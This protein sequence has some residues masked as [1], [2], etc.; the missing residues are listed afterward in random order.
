VQRTRPSGP[1]AGSG[2]PSGYGIKP[3]LSLFCG[4]DCAQKPLGIGCAGVRKSSL[5]VRPSTSHR[6]TFTRTRSVKSPTRRT[7]IHAEIRMTDMPSLLRSPQQPQGICACTVTSKAVVGSSAIRQTMGGRQSSG[8]R[9]HPLPHCPD[10]LVRIRVHARF[11]SVCD[12][13]QQIDGPFWASRRK[14]PDG[15]AGFPRSGH[16]RPTRISA[17]ASDPED[18]AMSRHAVRHLLSGSQ[19]NLVASKTDR[20][21][22]CGCCASWCSPRIE[23][24]V[25]DFPEPLSS[26]RSRCSLG[27]Q[28]TEADIC[29][30]RGSSHLRPKHH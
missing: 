6:H 25:T 20:P 22:G 26:P 8:W 13:I 9:H 4:R 21:W 7:Q 10:K 3:P 28:H 19:A 2:I 23:R 14:A 18:I 5:R 29:R 16:P 17:N 15:C 1:V 12:Q 30:S 24:G 11:A 27:W